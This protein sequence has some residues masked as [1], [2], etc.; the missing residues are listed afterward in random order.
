VF[1]AFSIPFFSF[2]VDAEGMHF[3]FLGLDGLF[4]WLFFYF[5]GMEVSLFPSRLIPLPLFLFEI[6]RLFPLFFP[7]FL[8]VF[9]SALPSFAGVMWDAFCLF[10]TLSLTPGSVFCMIFCAGQGLFSP[11]WMLARPFVFAWCF[12]LSPCFVS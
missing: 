8:S 2:P 11:S 10:W 1:F 7:I 9:S 5:F 4:F 6:G 3:F 12:P